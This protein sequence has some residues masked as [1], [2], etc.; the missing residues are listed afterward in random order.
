VE[1]PAQYS[2]VAAGLLW[3]LGIDRTRYYE[4]V[5]KVEGLYKKLG[6]G[7]SVFFDRE[8]F[9]ADRLVPG[10][11]RL[12]IR[13][14]LA[15]S[16]LPERARNDLARLYDGKEDYLPGLSSDEKKKKLAHVSYRDYLV[17]IAKADAGVVPFSI[18]DPWVSSALGS[19]PFPRSTPGRW[20][21]PASVDSVSSSL[22]PRG[23]L[24]SLAG[25]RP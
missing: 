13:E 8:T 6:L 17:T 24:P 3:E 18:R 11:G 21:F 1:A 16:P 20:S 2:T 9:G 25:A 22:L 19:T 15:A 14:F 5:A 23:S 10:Y 7:Y 4:S 12:P